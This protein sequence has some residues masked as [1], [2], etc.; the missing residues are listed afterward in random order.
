[1]GNFFFRPL[2]ATMTAL[3][4]A[5]GSVLGTIMA[6]DSI[7]TDVSA[8]PE[9][10]VACFVCLNHHS[11]WSEAASAHSKNSIFAASL[12]RLSIVTGLM[13]AI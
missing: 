10:E 6:A 3:S 5:I 4:E 1:M 11:S 13:P 9:D 12:D 7:W 2:P 8:L